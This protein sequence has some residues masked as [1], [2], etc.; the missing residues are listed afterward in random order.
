MVL[1]IPRDLVFELY[2]GRWVDVTALAERRSL[3]QVDPVTVGWG[4]PG[5]Q[6]RALAPP[7]VAEGVLNNDGGHWTPGNPMGEWYDYLL[8]RN[9][10]SRLML[11]VGRDTFSRTVGAGLGFTDT[12]E[13]WNTAGVNDSYSVGSGAGI[14]SI[15]AVSSFGLGFVAESYPDCQVAASVLVNINDVT[16]GSIEPLNLVLRHQA[17]G[18]FAGEHYMLRVVVS[19]AEVL[20]VAIFHSSLGALSSTATVPGLVDAVSPKN[21]RAKFQVEGQTLRGKVYRRGPSNDPDQ[22]EPV[23]WQ[24]SAHHD[25]LSGGFPG[26]RNGIASGNTNAK[27]IAFLVDDFELRL[28]QHVGELASLQPSWDESHKIKTARFKA[29]DVT[30]RLGRTQRT[31]LSSAARRYLAEG[32]NQDFTPTDFWPLD[33]A[34][35]APAQGLNLIAGGANA[36]FRRET[37]VVPNRGA[38][39]WG[40]SDARNPAVPSFATLSN[41]GRLVCTTQQAALGSAWSA[42]WI[43][44]VSP[45]AGAVVFLSTAAVVNRFAFF[46]YTD[47]TYDLFSNPSGTAVSSGVLTEAGLDG[48]WVTLG[49]TAFPS[50]ADTDVRVFVNGENRG[51]GVVVADAGMSPLAEVALFV[52]QPITGGQGDSAFSSVFVTPTRLDTITGGKFIGERADW[53]IMGW[54]GEAAGLRAFRLAAEEG[55]AFDYYGDLGDTRVMGPQRPEPLLDQITGCAEVDGAFLFSPRY[56]LGLAYRPRRAMCVQVPTATLLYDSG[57][58]SSISLSADD[59]PTANY[60]KAQKTD[61]GFVVVEQTVGPMNTKNPDSSPFDPDAVGRTPAEV[62]VNVESEVQL[63]DVGGWVRALGTVPEMR[64]PRVEVELSNRDLTTGLDPN[65]PAREVTALKPGDR[66]LVQGMASADVWRELD[67]IVRGGRTTFTT[68]YQHRV[69]IN[70]APYEKY[71]SGVFG[72]VTHRYDGPGQTTTLDALL[73][74]GVTGARAVT[75]TVGMP[76][77]T[78]AAAFA[79]D[80]YVIVGGEVMRLSGITGAGLMAQTMTIAARAVNG[81]VKS[82]PAGSRVH[83]YQ[84]CY[85]Q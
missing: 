29:A 45:D 65:K 66:M 4:S 9:V 76:W 34:S 5:E 33:E 74:A 35:N 60:V 20:T 75:T 62:D 58:V 24:V 2:L 55:V 48:Q 50:G 57:H 26:V 73:G 83:L 3:R 53:A 42:M 11:R 51:G 77:T 14:W 21:L 68:R 85:Y 71:K 78:S 61:G 17:S 32:K 39:K 56:S 49:V 47:G 18:V 43:M 81:V 79:T 27:P 8:T 1:S 40:E 13:G 12:G 54:R 69:A 64:F 22:F 44:R 7:S 16:G 67:Q 59:R 84:P 19:S 30:Q 72:E 36:V 10:P 38:V 52:P 6:S 31:A 63:G 80:F 28:A 41:G 82:H 37:G 15:S 23:E 25:R 70:T 46:L